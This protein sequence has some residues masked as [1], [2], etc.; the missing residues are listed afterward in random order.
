MTLDVQT[1]N[2][3]FPND[4]FTVEI[5]GEPSNTVTIRSKH[6]P[7]NICLLLKINREDIIVSSLAKCD[8]IENE[9]TGRQLMLKVE[10]LAKKIG[11]IGYIRIYDDSK[12]HVCG[13]EIDLFYLKIIMKGISWYNSLG[14][15]SDNYQYEINHNNLIINSPISVIATQLKFDI[16]LFDSISHEETVQQYVSRLFNSIQQQHCRQI[17]KEYGNYV[18]TIIDKISNLLVYER[19]LVKIISKSAGRRKRQTR[20]RDKHKNKK[21]NKKRIRKINSIRNI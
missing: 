11:G 21:T 5:I 18:K 6:A 8:S 7:S 12:I 14:Y 10:L 4:K 15:E 2:E 20:H 17:D 13:N 9:G 3:I 16:G 19:Q 1:I